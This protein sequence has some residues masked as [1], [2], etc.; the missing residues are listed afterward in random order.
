MESKISTEFLQTVK[1]AKRTSPEKEIP[2][3][4]T[5]EP[6]AA[7]DISSSL[8]DAGLKVENRFSEINSVSGKITAK[9]IEKLLQVA[10]VKKVD[11]DSKM[12]ALGQ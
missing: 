11:P 9:S 2:V 10:E 8:E 1:E 6:S 12:Y 3:I 4:V 5:Y 7:A